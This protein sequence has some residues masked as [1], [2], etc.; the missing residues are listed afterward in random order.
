MKIAFISTLHGGNWGGSETLWFETAKFLQKQGQE[1]ITSVADDQI[2]HQTI[3]ERI[4]TFEHTHFWANPTLQCNNR[5]NYKSRLLCKIGIKQVNSFHS[6]QKMQ[7]DVICISQGGFADI[8]HNTDLLEYILATDVPFVIINHSYSPSDLQ[9]NHQRETLKKI[10]T[11]SKKV[12]FVSNNQ[13]LEIERTLAFSTPNYG[14]VLNPIKFS[15][16]EPSTFPSFESGVKFCI[17]SSLE[18]KWKGQ[19]ILL[20]TLSDEKWKSRDWRFEIFGSGSDSLYLQNLIAHYNLEEKV[21]LKGETS[22]VRLAFKDKHL[23]LFP[24]RQDVVPLSML[25]AMCCA[26]PVLVTRIGGMPEWVNHGETGY[27]S[28]APTPFCL[29]K[30]LEEAWTN[31]PVWSEMGLRSFQFVKNKYQINPLNLLIEELTSNSKS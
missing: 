21:V 15:A 2:S 5:V 7:P 25:E 18:T 10:Y 23:I 6:L 1:V 12:L 28:D 26:R 20:Q 31:K 17:L 8:V 29:D 11:K 14:I 27:I 24:S 16:S 22:D 30:A 13:K 19:D 9:N 4:G 3:K